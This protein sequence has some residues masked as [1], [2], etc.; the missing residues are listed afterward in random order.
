M[1]GLPASPEDRQVA[2]TIGSQGNNRSTY[3][4]QRPRRSEPQLSSRQCR[5]YIL[6]TDEPTM[7]SL[8]TL[9]NDGSTSVADRIDI[10]AAL[11]TMPI[12][13]LARTY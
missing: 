12:M 10:M 1:L 3:T 13:H 7:S 2:D 11:L 8:H 4:A 6:A 9:A 5:L